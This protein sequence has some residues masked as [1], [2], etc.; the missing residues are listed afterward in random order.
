MSNA[1]LLIKP[2]PS[3]TSM[4]QH[5]SHSHFSQVIIQNTLITVH[6]KNGKIYY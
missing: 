2:V 6:Q 1:Q 5:K 4:V 3:C